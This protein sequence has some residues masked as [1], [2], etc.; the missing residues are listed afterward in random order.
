MANSKIKDKS[1]AINCT[2]FQRPGRFVGLKVYGLLKVGEHLQTWKKLTAMHA[3]NAKLKEFSSVK[4]GTATSE[5]LLDITLSKPHLE[6]NNR[7][8]Y[9]VGRG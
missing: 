3:K 6:E 4:P 1:E 9:Q 8:E 7:G 2:P 5:H